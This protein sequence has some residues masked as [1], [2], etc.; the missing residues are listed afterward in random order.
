MEVGWRQWVVFMDRLCVLGMA[1]APLTILGPRV[2]EANDA[3]QCHGI[4]A[5]LQRYTPQLP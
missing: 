3:G 4:E 5:H 1:E 2:P